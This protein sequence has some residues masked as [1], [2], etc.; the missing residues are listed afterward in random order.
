MPCVLQCR[1][2]FELLVWVS[3]PGA[4]GGVCRITL[5]QH[6]ILWQAKEKAHIGKNT[7]EDVSFNGAIVECKG[8]LFRIIAPLLVYKEAIWIPLK[9]I[10]AC[11]LWLFYGCSPL[12][13]LP[14]CAFIS[15]SEWKK[16]EE[17]HR[18]CHFDHC[19]QDAGFSFILCCYNP[20]SP[21]ASSSVSTSVMY[22]KS[23][24]ETICLGSW[25]DTR[26]HYISLVVA[27][28]R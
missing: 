11:N 5:F 26:K 9:P 8:L 23:M 14:S 17:K 1:D 18:V 28:W 16:R 27:S 25:I 13:F 12:C 19:L 7:W 3:K 6:L 2:L 22:L 4:G 20:V 24:H 21:T 15:M 10:K